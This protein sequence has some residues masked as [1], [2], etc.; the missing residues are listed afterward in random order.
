MLGAELADTGLF[1]R[2]GALHF[3]IASVA[4]LLSALFVL[5]PFALPRLLAH[6]NLARAGVAILFLRLGL[7]LCGTLLDGRSWRNELP[8]HLCPAALI[9]GSLYFI[10][11]RPIF[12]NL[13]YFWHFGSFV[14]VLYPDLTRAHTILYAYLFMPTHCLEPAMVVFS[15]LHLRERISKRGLQCAVLGFLLLAANALFWNRRLGAN[16]LF[17]SKYPLEILRV[18]RPFFVYQLLFVSA[19]CLLMLVLYLPFR[20]SQHG[21]NQLFVI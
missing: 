13:L 8:F 6:K 14:V 17:I 21:R 20:P 3:A 5:L 12:F 16:Y 18:I 15:L 2:F 19:L 10:T 1:V 11:R 4:V 9:S 7:M